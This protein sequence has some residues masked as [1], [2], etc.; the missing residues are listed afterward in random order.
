MAKSQE[1]RTNMDIILLFLIKP[2]DKHGV[3][4][5][6]IT[7]PPLQILPQIYSD[8]SAIVVT[9]YHLPKQISTEGF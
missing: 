9:D 6:D 8:G 4:L 7:Y 2:V 3:T 1:N 5:V